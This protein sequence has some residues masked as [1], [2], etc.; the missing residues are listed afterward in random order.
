MSKVDTNENNVAKQKKINKNDKS[1]KIRTWTC[2]K[3]LV[4]YMHF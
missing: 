3:I 4:I 2:E 1:T